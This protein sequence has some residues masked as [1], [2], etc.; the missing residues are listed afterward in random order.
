MPE[1]AKKKIIERKAQ[2]KAAAEA[3]KPADAANPAA[4]AAPAEGAKP[5]DAAAPDEGGNVIDFTAPAP[6]SDELPAGDVVIEGLDEAGK[7]KLAKLN[8][9]LKTFR[10]R[11]QEAEK[12]AAA[13][14]ELESKTQTL[15]AEL[16]TLRNTSGGGS[17]WYASITEPATLDQYETHLKG[18]LR[19]LQ[20]AS[21]NAS[22][23]REW[24][25]L[26]GTKR[27]LTA[28]D[29]DTLTTALDHIDQRRTAIAKTTE[30]GAVAQGIIA[31]MKAV[32]GFD[33]LHAKAKTVNWDHDR[34]TLAAKIA[35]ADLA[36][37]GQYKLV[38]Q[39]SSEKAGSAKSEPAPTSGASPKPGSEAQPRNPPP[40]IGGTTPPA[41]RGEDF[42]AALS[43][44]QARA[45]KGDTKAVAEILRIKRQMRES[46]QAAA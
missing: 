26:D 5:G 3:G 24:T 32:E 45:A 37:S 7:A 41:K 30:S 11:V 14:K 34:P 13:A 19:Q 35:I 15:E 23:S 44:A 8:H 25:F 20:R 31:K 2:A 36:L 16:E 6:E 33:A 40:E 27:D 29:F 1:S 46:Q 43:S 17:N 39:G 10:N 12:A 42:T 9:K 28:D 18:A 4:P 38:K 22:E 21:M